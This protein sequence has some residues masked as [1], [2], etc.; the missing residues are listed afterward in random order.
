MRLFL[1]TISTLLILTSCHNNTSTTNNIVT[2]EINSQVRRLNYKPEKVNQDSYIDVEFLENDVSILLN[3]AV[4]DKSKGIV[5]S[6]ITD[7][8]NNTIYKGNINFQ[9]HVIDP[10]ESIF[11]DS[12]YADEGDTSVFLPPTP[13]LQMKAGNY[14]FEIKRQDNEPLKKVEVFIKSVETNENVDRLSYKI[15]MNVWVADPEITSNGDSEKL[16]FSDFKKKFRNSYKNTINQILAPHSLELDQINFYLANPAATIKYADLSEDQMAE[17]CHEMN[18]VI[19]DN[20]A[21]NL[22]FMR[23]LT[24]GAGISPSPGNIMDKTASNGCFYVSHSAYIAN[25]EVGFTEELAQQMMA[26]NILHESA[27][28]LSLEHPTEETGTDFDH[29]D[30][31]PECDAATHDGRDNTEDFGGLIPGTKDGIISDFECGRVGGAN[32]FLFYSGVFYYLPFVMS[33]DQA[34]TLRR[35]PLTILKR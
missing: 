20:F 12:L 27:H 14:R 16:S 10:I 24:S 1:I 29:F 23:S 2:T 25:E 13:R 5:I 11:V 33:A 6:K 18:K 19:T 34:A 15:N 26:G 30:D 22:G 32:N 8:D 17:A 31:T 3:T 28:F 4:E 21:L 7:P 35:H 9:T